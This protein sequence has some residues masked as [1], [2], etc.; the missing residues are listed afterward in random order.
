M[1]EKAVM[2]LNH[3]DN[4]GFTLIEILISLAMAS[5]V[6]MAIYALFV[7][8]HRIYLAQKQIADIQQS[9]RSCMY[10]L[11]SNIKHACFD[12][13]NSAS[14]AI[15][16]ADKQSFGFQA[17]LNSNGRLQS[18]KTGAG[19]TATTLVNDSNEQVTYGFSK[20]TQGI[21]NLTQSNWAAGGAD[22]ADYIECLNFVYLDENGAVIS[23]LPLSQSDRQRIRS[24]EVTLVA[25]SESK[26]PRHFDNRTYTN[27]RG[28]ELIKQPNDN[29]HRRSLSKIILL[30]NMTGT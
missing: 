21:G 22:M 17:D 19:G 10:L 13:L 3:R 7:V 28:E 14:P 9:L 27:L 4:S 12:P 29:Y 11:E 6:S 8:Q 25:R 15:I 24:V 5:I 20:T 23:P 16:V 26:D 18:E 2:R 30:R 1:G